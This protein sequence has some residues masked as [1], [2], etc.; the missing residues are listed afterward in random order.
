MGAA[1]ILLV[2]TPPP[3]Y[4][5]LQSGADQC[6]QLGGRPVAC[7]E[8]L[9]K[10]VVQRTIDL[11]MRAGLRE[12]AL[13]A[14]ASALEAVSV[15][16]GSECRIETHLLQAES[17]SSYALQQVITNLLQRDVDNVFLV[18]LG[19]YVEFDPNE[20]VQAARDGNVELLRLHDGKGP[21]GIWLLHRPKVNLAECKSPGDWF[22]A[23]YARTAEPYRVD[24]Y[25]NRLAGMHDLRRLVR[26]MFASGCDARPCGTEIKPGIW[27]D[28]GAHIHRQARVLRPA[29]IGRKTR[30]AAASLITRGSSVERDCTVSCGTVIEDS[31]ILAGTYIGTGLDVAHSIVFEKNLLNL[32]RELE[33][34]IYDEML[35]AENSASRLRKAFRRPGLELVKDLATNTKS[36]HSKGA[37]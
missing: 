12:I 6:L 20:V 17:D 14:D 4:G 24:G 2:G 11:F 31:S 16:G 29:Y 21:L 36:T 28:Q 15:H 5:V 23:E 9:G 26:D 3:A 13:M 35:I 33:L 10:S 37:L 25:V 34:E 18:W 30:I 1:A 32:Q 22:T 19:H 7:L 27:V 8:V